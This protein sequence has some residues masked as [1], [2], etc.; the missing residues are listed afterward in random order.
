MSNDSKEKKA[1]NNLVMRERRR[2]FK[3][4]L[5]SKKECCLKYILKLVKYK[6][7]RISI[8]NYHCILYKLRILW[9]TSIF[10]RRSKYWKIQPPV[11]GICDYIEIYNT[12]Q[13]FM[14][15]V[16]IL[17]FLYKRYKFGEFFFLELT[18]FLVYWW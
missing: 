5:W 17:Y 7:Q 6:P 16:Y 11:L 12:I 9:L 2:E 14:P 4:Q 10:I 8:S 3:S 15:F 13:C 1:I 18:G